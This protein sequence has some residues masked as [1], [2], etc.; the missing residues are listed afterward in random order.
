MLLQSQQITLI[1]DIACQSYTLHLLHAHT[2]Q[3]QVQGSMVTRVSDH[4]QANLFQ[5]QLGRV[6]RRIGQA[7]GRQRDCTASRTKDQTNN[8]TPFDKQSTHTSFP[9]SLKS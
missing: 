9:L 5:G 1:R 2:S 7:V 8:Q 3:R 6:E 4:A